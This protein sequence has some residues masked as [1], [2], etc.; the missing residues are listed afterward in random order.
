[1]QGKPIMLLLLLSLNVNAQ[2]TDVFTEIMNPG[3]LAIHGNDLY[4][5]RLVEKKISKIDLSTPVPADQDVID[6]LE[7]SPLFFLFHGSEMYIA[8]NNANRISLT[9]IQSSP[10]QAAEVASG[11]GSPAGL[12]LS[13]NH[14]YVS[15]FD[16][17][18]I[19]MIDI[20]AGLPAMAVQVV[21]GLSKPVGLVLDGDELYIA[22]FGMNKLSKINVTDPIPMVT[23]VVTVIL[24]PFAM[25]LKDK[26]LYIS[27]YAQG[28]IVSMDIGSDVPAPV[29]LVEGLVNPNG[30]VSDSSYLYIS[31]RGAGKISKFELNVTGLPELEPQDRVRIYPNPSSDFIRLENLPAN[32]WIE[33]LEPTGVRILESMYREGITM[34]VRSLANGIYIIRITGS[35]RSEAH[36]I[37][38]Q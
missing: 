35:G 25:T 10:P 17:G 3:G 19:S 13:G 37:I 12:A 15:E 24:G 36:T 21:S 8:E 29:V 11:L 28:R 31:E 38:K 5:G 22:E 9:D 32:S 2:L 4:F 23:D 30:L 16:S 1:M 20:S 34:D 7:G 33:I 14:L 26:T 27:E 18:R 6:S